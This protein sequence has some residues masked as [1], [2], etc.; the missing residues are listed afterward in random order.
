MLNQKYFVTLQ[1]F[2]RNRWQDEEFPV[3]LRRDDKQY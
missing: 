2:P 1:R 3:M